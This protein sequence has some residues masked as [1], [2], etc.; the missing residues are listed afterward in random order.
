M[1][2]SLRII[3]LLLISSVALLSSCKKVGVNTVLVPGGATAL[4]STQTTLVLVQ[5]NAANAAVTF[6]WGKADFGF[7][8]AI[9]YTLEMTKGGTNFA[10]SSTTSVSVGNGLTKSFTVGE[11]NNKMQDI[12][13]DGTPAA[14]QVRVKAEVSPQAA[15][16]FSNVLTMTITSYMDIVTYAFPAAMNVAG[17]YQGWSPVSAPQIVNTRNGGYAGYEGFIIFNHAT[18]AFKLVKGN[19]WSAGDY[20]G[21]AGGVISSPG[22]DITLPSGGPGGTGLYRLRANTTALTWSYYKVN[23]WGIIGD[24]TPLDWGASSPMTFN[25]VNGSWTITCDLIGGKFMKF[26]ANNDWALNF[27]DNGTP[28]GKPEYDGSNI[29]VALS[30]N[31][32]I[33]LN[34]GVGGN[35]S[36]KLKKN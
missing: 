25:P 18:P 15:P 9:T 30:G 24:A 2:S 29:P 6:T 8:A 19:D 27:G 22:S 3:S 21:T 16:I 5:A 14:I 32:T 31:Y 34:L 7:P 11:F 4:T 35:Y 23:T 20:G 36:Y 1:K 10:T 17:N 13:V 28:D 26:R 12:I 33:T